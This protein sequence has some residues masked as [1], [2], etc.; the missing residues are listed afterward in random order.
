MKALTHI[1]KVNEAQVAFGKKLDLDLHGCTVTV[2]AARIEDAIDLGFRSVSDLGAP[3]QKQIELAAKFD[4]DIIG[5]SRREATAI[6]EDLMIQ[7]NKEIIEYERL[8]PGVVVRNIHGPPDMHYIISSIHED[9]TVYFRG[10]NGR[11]AW[12][13]S[14]RRVLNHDCARISETP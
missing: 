1:R 11:R 6:I 14:L 12:A 7:L 3:T 8:A 9:G 10:G 4:Y 13:R 5:L 2:A